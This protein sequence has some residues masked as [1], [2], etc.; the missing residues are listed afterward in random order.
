MDTLSPK[1]VISNHIDKMCGLLK[2]YPDTVVG[3]LNHEKSVTNDYRGRVLYELLQNAVDRADENIWINFDR[4][5]KSLIV[6]NDG[7]GFGF[8]PR[9]TE[10]RSDFAAVCAI[11]ASN[12]KMGRSIG[13]KGVGFKSI[14]SLC[15]S[16]Q[17]RTRYQGSESWGFRLRS[18]FHSDCLAS[19]DD[20]PLAKKIHDHL[21][22]DNLEEKHQ[23]RAPSFYFPEYLSAPHWNYPD[24]VT[25][26]E[27]E[28]IE[29]EYFETIETLI[30]ELMSRPLIF[31]SSIRDNV[32]L[33][34]TIN[35]SHLNEP[36]SAPL[37]INATDWIHLDVDVENHRNELE[38]ELNKLGVQLGRLPRLTLA[39]RRGEIS[40]NDQSGFVHSYLPTNQKTGMFIE[41]HGDFYLEESRKAV[42]FKDTPYNSL[43][44]DLAVNALIEALLKN[45]HGICHLSNSLQ[46]IKSN[47]LIG[48]RIRNKLR[49]NG[50]DL[51]QILNHILNAPFV[52]TGG[53]YK[54]L[55]LAI[56]HFI[57]DKEE[58]RWDAYYEETL[59]PF[60]QE[61]IT[62][63]LPLIPTA[64]VLTENNEYEV[65]KALPW[66]SL[67]SK[68]KFK[69]RVFIR[70]AKQD[71]EAVSVPNI[72]VTEWVP[73]SDNKLM[74]MLKQFDL[75]TDYDRIPVLRAIS[76]AIQYEDNSDKRIDL[77]NVARSVYSP[78][79]LCTQTQWQFLDAVESHPSQRLYL[80]VEEG[81]WKMV[82]DI[83]VG[84]QCDSYRD[85]IDQEEFSFL[86]E[87]KC[88]A[89][90]GQNWLSVVLYW[91]CWSC[92]PLKKLNNQFTSKSQQW[93]VVLKNA[94][95][96]ILDKNIVIKS[97]KVWCQGLNGGRQS[98][99][100][101][102]NQLSHLHFIPVQYDHSELIAPIDVFWADSNVIVKGFFTIN[103]RNSDG[104]IANE[105]YVKLFIESIDETTDVGK[106]VRLAKR[107]FPTGT[108]SSA[109]NSAPLA[110][111]RNIIKQINRSPELLQYDINSLQDLPIPYES[112]KCRGILALDDG[113]AWYI[114][115]VLRSSKAKFLS[116]QHKVWLVTGD[117]ATLANQL[118]NIKTLSSKP[119][120]INAKGVFDGD[121][122][123]KLK[124]KYLPQFLAMV[125][126]SDTASVE[127][128][129]ESVLEKRWSSVEVYRVD[130]AILVEE[131]LD[132]DGRELVLK[133]DIRDK[134]ILWRPYYNEAP[135]Q[136]RL[137][138]ALGI[139]VDNHED[140]VCRWF[141]DEVFR[142][143][144]LGTKFRQLLKDPAI[145]SVSESE[146]NDAKSLIN[147]WL[148]S[149]V[150]AELVK[151]IENSTGGEFSDRHWRDFSYYK[152]F[153]IDFLQLYSE[154]PM[155]LK[156]MI[157]LLDPTQVNL[158]ALE[159][160]LQRSSSN[161][162]AL[163]DAKKKN[164][165]DWL[166]KAKED[167]ALQTFNF[168][169]KNWLLNLLDMTSCE[170]DQLAFKVDFDLQKL[171]QDA[172]V[173]KL[174]DHTV[175]SSSVRSLSNGH[176]RA[177][178]PVSTTYATINDEDRSKSQLNNSKAGKSVEAQLALMRA[179]LAD[180]LDACH[181]VKF[182]QLLK[183]E[184]VNRP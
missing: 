40:Q 95:I 117:V 66:P 166:A 176:A 7:E 136:L 32:A 57:P 34:L 149:D 109:I 31:V 58:H 93:Q 165:S 156:L 133:T 138:V 2:H 102:F 1:Q 132:S 163:P 75:F 62:K 24:E 120:S 68:G 129:S 20:Q 107:I 131:T 145:F 143:R 134:G 30:D 106:L 180:G 33:K 98:L 184:Y 153:N 38:I 8:Q 17:I 59:K 157:E 76:Q 61:F 128:I 119:K 130:E 142:T 104:E 158:Q 78:Q 71:L 125:N 86:D 141:A 87:V 162:A 115:G 150:E 167:R 90:F 45:E 101:L 116:D 179:K 41:L 85:L 10:A 164:P 80:P 60:F 173:I 46:L 19:W 26:I 112:S 94:S 67:D 108:L 103:R 42:D 84:S 152:E 63:Q 16:V 23:G 114:P 69:G 178:R 18:P 50:V 5:R 182:V 81:G 110:V 83:V 72:I 181:K 89:I 15:N 169:S 82:R 12:K 154:A 124:T 13:N 74:P 148:S 174:L 122:L 135:K 105:L 121:L 3:H 70:K 56:G 6:A 9:K 147:D 172:D 77:L 118:K 183:Q 100:A 54:D 35:S 48:L 155:S 29:P 144:D 14:W 39:L 175:S 168:D 53:W 88:K 139:D 97:W 96:H 79:Q 11:D 160:L 44:L 151:Y 65:V 25:A 47:E 37:S 99:D 111:Y 92:L 64:L 73:P 55:Y 127:S 28:N 4:N 49:G 140:Q 91:G 123:T 137:Y 36:H 159:D 43:L 27:L 171:Q 52:K 177:V 170:F 161:I 113:T 22:L 126:Y 146:I 21:K 51:A